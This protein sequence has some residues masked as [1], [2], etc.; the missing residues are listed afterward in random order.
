MII[1]FTIDNHHRI[2]VHLNTNSS[3]TYVYTLGISGVCMY[4]FD[5]ALRKDTKVVTKRPRE[6]LKAVHKY[7]LTLHRQ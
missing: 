2:T 3:G 1:T 5:S 4:L 7:R 6:V